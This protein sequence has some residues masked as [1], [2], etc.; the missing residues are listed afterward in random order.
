MLVNRKI[1]FDTETTGLDWSSG[2][3]IVELGCVE[4]VNDVPTGRTFQSYVDPER[5]MDPRSS[6]VSG[7]TDAM[8]AG[9]PLFA[10]VAPD[11]LAFMGDSPLVI[12]NAQFDM[13]F[14]NMELTRAG[15]APL[16]TERAIDT[17]AIA[18]K[19]YPGQPASLDALCRRFGIDLSAR[20]KHGALLDA[21]LLADVWLHLIGGRQRVL[22]LGGAGHGLD[23]AEIV[24]R[25]PRSVP[26]PPRLSAEEAAAHEA[27]I[28]TLKGDVLWRRYLVD[29]E[30]AE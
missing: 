9:Q 24:R 11:L 2:D 28:A 14:L 18:R 23:E 10:A 4:L 15:F 5:P 12:H 13:G 21:G 7:I 25:E 3:R 1:A 30:A 19:R 17:V 20:V 29:R 26:L 6:E 8:L 16:P 22:G 27:F